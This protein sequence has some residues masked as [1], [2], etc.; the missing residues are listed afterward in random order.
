MAKKGGKGR[1]VAPR[2]PARRLP[3]LEQPI[4]DRIIR[5]LDP[6]T[7]SELKTLAKCCLVSKTCLETARP[8]LYRVF[9]I[10][11]QMDPTV[12]AERKAMGAHLR[13][14]EK[15]VPWDDEEFRAWPKGLM[16]RTSYDSGEV[17]DR[18]A[19]RMCLSLELHKHLQSL[20]K[21]L[22]VFGQHGYGSLAKAIERV[23]RVLPKVDVVKFHAHIPAKTGETPTPEDED[24]SQAP[25]SIRLFQPIAQYRHTLPVQDLTVLGTYARAAP[26]V[27]DGIAPMSSLKRLRLAFARHGSFWADISDPI[28]RETGR[29]FWEPTFSLQ[30]LRLETVFSPKIFKH[31]TKTSCT[32]LTSLHL[33]IREHAIDLSDFPLLRHLGI[34]YSRPQIAVETMATAT[35]HLRT[36]ELRKDRS[37]QWDDLKLV[38]D[39]LDITIESLTDGSFLSKLGV[40]GDEFKSFNTVSTVLA[41]L[42][43]SITRL[44]LSFYLGES[45]P[46]LLFALAIPR[47]LPDLK[48]LDV[49]DERRL[50]PDVQ[51][52]DVLPRGKKE[53]EVREMREKVRAACEKRG[54]WMSAYARPWEEDEAGLE[55]MGR[56][57]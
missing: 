26:G 53:R 28:N 6:T 11:N 23:T 45:Y 55:A 13:V 42:P 18:T 8:I 43:N 41:Q 3:T 50:N 48:V 5:F 47:W 56:R 39:E 21:E 44:T 27:F 1:T 34:A 30:Y 15:L 33:A 4:V 40:L 2:V 17:L 31:L 7:K 10:V 49:A 22:H 19:K 9:V 16:W 35:S 36:L 38:K 14:L 54:V 52:G 29:Y 57:P 20:V 32:T 24:A 25:L 37:I 46:A 12:I 51:M